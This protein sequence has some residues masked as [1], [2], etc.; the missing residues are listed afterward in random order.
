MGIT[1]DVGLGVVSMLAELL[2]ILTDL[3]LKLELELEGCP[4]QCV[5]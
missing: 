5:P 2:P 4:L 1:V 3:E